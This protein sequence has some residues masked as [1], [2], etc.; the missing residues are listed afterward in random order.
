VWGTRAHLRP[1]EIN[2]YRVVA[3]AIGISAPVAGFRPVRAERWP[4]ENVP[5]P[6]NCMD[7]AFAERRCDDLEHGLDQ[8]GGGRLGVAAASRDRVDE[9]LLVHERALCL[10]AIAT[11]P[12]G[13]ARWQI[14]ATIGGAAVEL[15]KFC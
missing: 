8:I 12:Q 3:A 13:R 6:T 11:L 10:S 5:N 9:F 4:T 15:L 2:V 14:G 1:N 7:P